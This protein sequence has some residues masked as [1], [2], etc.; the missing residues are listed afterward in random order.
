MTDDWSREVEESGSGRVIR[1]G[2]VVYGSVLV[3]GQVING[4]TVVCGQTLAMWSEE[5]EAVATES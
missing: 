5:T 3:C 4:V 2:E 1:C